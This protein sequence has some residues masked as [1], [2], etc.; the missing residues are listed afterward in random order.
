MRC[1]LTFGELVI[2]HLVAYHCRY[3]YSVWELEWDFLFLFLLFSK[4]HSEV[5]TC[6]FLSAKT[7]RGP[8]KTGRRKSLI[9]MQKEETEGIGCLHEIILNE[10]K[11]MHLNLSFYTIETSG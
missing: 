9:K 5:E 3:R 1:L 4:E 7:G 8:K 6:F 2:K 10:K 11:V